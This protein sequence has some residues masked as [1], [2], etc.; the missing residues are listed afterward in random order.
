MT[1]NENVI[2]FHD[3][4]IG[5]GVAENAANTL[6]DEF[7]DI[8][9]NKNSPENVWPLLSHGCFKECYDLKHQTLEVIVKFASNCNETEKE[10]EIYNAAIAEGLGATFLPSVFIPLAVELPAQY[11]DGDS[12]YSRY[13][14]RYHTSQHT[15]VAT[16]NPEYEEPALNYAIVQ[17]RIKS[18]AFDT[19]GNIP[20]EYNEHYFR[21][22]FNPIKDKDGV[23]VEHNL[24][25]SLG[26]DS[27]SWLKSVAE[28]HGKDYIKALGN[29][30]DNNGIS[31]LHE[32][33]IGYLMN[34]EPVIFDW[35]S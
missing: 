12:E 9:E 7:R 28:K 33:N 6:T 1:I 25:Y 35:L 22:H 18:T 27:Y 8:L 34:D 3:A 2:Q 24:L 32:R 4:L 5:F 30:I 16:P 17:V 11:L 10:E 29:F 21:N 15:Y 31:D 14:W 26:V 23:E 13:N 19:P 20:F